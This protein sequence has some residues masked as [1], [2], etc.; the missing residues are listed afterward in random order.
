MRLILVGLVLTLGCGGSSQV[1]GR[2][3]TIRMQGPDCRM[4]CAAQVHPGEVLSDCTPPLDFEPTKRD[5]SMTVC[6]FAPAAAPAATE[7]DSR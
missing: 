1:V 4:A 2:S 7:P 5:P 3:M 6:F